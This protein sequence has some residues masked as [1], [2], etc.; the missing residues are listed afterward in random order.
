MNYTKLRLHKISRNFEKKDVKKE[1]RIRLHTL[2]S[3]M[4]KCIF[5]QKK[6]S[7]SF[8]IL[9]TEKLLCVK[10]PQGMG[11]LTKKVPK[12]NIHVTLELFW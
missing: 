7:E 10:S 11:D 9:G 12:G 5:F 2:N 1:T 6:I 3:A 4:F 8:C